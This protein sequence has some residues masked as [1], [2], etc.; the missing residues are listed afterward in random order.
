M[1]AGVASMADILFSQDGADALLT[2]GA[3][4][5]RLTGVTAATLTAADF[6]FAPTSAEELDDGPTVAANAEVKSDLIDPVM[7]DFAAPKTEDTLFDTDMAAM[8]RDAITIELPDGILPGQEGE[9]WVMDIYG[10]SL[11]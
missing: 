8:L 9:A 2:M 4:L 7:E 3:N 11:L 6:I 1:M 10:T 5:I